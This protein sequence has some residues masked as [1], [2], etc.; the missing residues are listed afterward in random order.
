MLY[1][2]K[3]VKNPEIEDTVKQCRRCMVGKTYDQF[4]KQRATKDGHQS[5]CK[6]CSAEY[7]REHYDS[8]QTRR[9]AR[10]KLNYGITADDF[11]RLLAEQGN[12][13]KLCK[14]PPKGRRLSAD[15][16]HVTGEFRGII[17][18]QCNTRLKWLRLD[19]GLDYVI[20]L[21]EYSGV[22]V[23]WASQD[24]RL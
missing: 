22:H 14:L 10:F 7:Q 18:N 2:Y 8:T 20:R 5:W 1:F 6:S 13:C 12:V 17:C 23:E 19:D 21:A 9:D 15:H 11:D 16:N 24:I 3:R 4:H